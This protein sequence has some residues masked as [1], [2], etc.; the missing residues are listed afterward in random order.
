MISGHTY[1][2]WL[3]IETTGLSSLDDS[4]LEIAYAVSSDYPFDVIERVERVIHFDRKSDVWIDPRVLAMHAENELFRECEES[5]LS[6]DRAEAHLEALLTPYRDQGSIILA[7]FSVHFDYEFLRVQMPGLAS[8]FSH[9]R[10][11]VSTLRR[12]AKMLGWSG[13]KGVS[14]HRAKSDVEASRACA[15]AIGRWINEGRK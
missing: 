10:F 9:W 14:L 8:M 11:D 1:Y 3:D 13:P 15:L 7:G 4:I 5:R 6:L 2:C 12:F